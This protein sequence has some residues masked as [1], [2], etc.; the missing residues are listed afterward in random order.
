MD[1]ADKALVSHYSSLDAPRRI[2]ILTKI[3]TFELSF[4]KQSKVTSDDILE[5]NF[6]D[7]FNKHFNDVFTQSLY[8]ALLPG[9][10]RSTRTDIDLQQRQKL[11]RNAIFSINKSKFIYSVFAE[12]LSEDIEKTVAVSSPMAVSLLAGKSLVYKHVDTFKKRQKDLE[13]CRGSLSTAAFD[14]HKIFLEP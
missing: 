3:L 5:G 12:A 11:F 8:A 1:Q 2:E 13:V 14:R 4:Q 6:V 10:R 7:V 9:Y